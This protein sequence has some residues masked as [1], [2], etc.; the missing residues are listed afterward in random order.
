MIVVRLNILRNLKFSSRGLMFLGFSINLVRN[1]LSVLFSLI[2]VIKKVVC[3]FVVL[4]L[5]EKWGRC[6]KRILYGMF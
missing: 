3:M 5:I 2:I 6:I 1:L 4:Y